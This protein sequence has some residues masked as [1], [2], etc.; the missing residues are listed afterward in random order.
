MLKK[1]ILQEIKEILDEGDVIDIFSR[2]PRKPIKRPEV[3]IPLTTTALEEAENFVNE[4][5]CKALTEEHM[6]QRYAQQGGGNPNAS[7]EEQEAGEDRARVER[8]LERRYS[9]AR[10]KVCEAIKPPKKPRPGREERREFFG[11]F[12]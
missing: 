4:E 7:E 9:E 1:L 2:Q 10:K 6:R 12:Q 11:G 5:L 8:W 3:E